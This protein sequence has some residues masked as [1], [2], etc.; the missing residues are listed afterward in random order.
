VWETSFSYSIQNWLALNEENYK[1]YKGMV[2]L[3][4]KLTLLERLLTGN[5]L[6]FAKGIEW[7]VEKPVKVELQ[8]VRGE[9][10]IRYKGVPLVA[11]DVQFRCNVSLPNYLGLGKSASHGFGI[12]RQYREQR[13]EN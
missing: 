3:T 13:N 8:E 7:R 5:I 1:R 10:I 12:V 2:G 6:S 4:E 11:F 9:K